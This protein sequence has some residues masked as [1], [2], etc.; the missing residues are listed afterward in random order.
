MRIKNWTFFFVLLS[1]LSISIFAQTS[2]T[3]SKTEKEKIQ[4]E[5]EKR[6]LKMLDE[7]VN[8]AGTL[9][10]AQN[11]A[12]VYAIAGDLY[13]KF[14]E[15]RAREFFRSSANDILVANSEAEK[16]KKADDDPYSQVFDFEDNYR[17]EILPLVA[18]HD[19]DLALDLL[20][21]T[22]SVKLADAMARA[23]QPTTKQDNDFMSFNPERYRVRGEIALEQSFALQAAEQN[24]D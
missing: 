8:D 1:L 24:P 13:W 18:K 20:V 2:P 21:Q 22:R 6:V 12:I 19:A 7:A 4:K 9:K 11:R 17:N 14:D 3:E 5:L 23:A 15:K 16:E 10:L